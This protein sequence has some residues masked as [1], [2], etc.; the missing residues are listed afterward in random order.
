M[1]L[2]TDTIEKLCKNNNFPLIQPY[3]ANENHDNP[4][5]VELHLGRQCYCSN[6]TNKIIELK[7]LGTPVILKPNTIFLFETE[8]SFNFP[9]NLSGHISLK[10]G[11]IS[12]GLVMASQTQVDPG[13]RNNLFGM[14]YNLSS[15][16]VEIKRGQAIITLEVFQTEPSQHEYSGKMQNISFEQFVKTRIGSSLSTLEKDI[17]QSQEKLDSSIKYWNRFSSCIA[18]VLTLIS[19]VITIANIRAAWK[20]DAEISALEYQVKTLTDKIQDYKSIIEQQNTLINENEARIR[21]LEESA[22]MDNV[23]GNIN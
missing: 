5:K 3:N 16:N 9:N 21:K 23:D 20:D 13:Y 15:E 2:S 19:I 22:Y 6:S 11:L 14:I 8:E 10:M 18:V 17:R 4:A 7:R 12:K 1:I